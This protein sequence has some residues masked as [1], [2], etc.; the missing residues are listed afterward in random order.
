MES[1]HKPLLILTGPTGAGKT[2][3]SLALAESAAIQIINIDRGQWYTPLT[4]GTAKPAWRESSVKQWLFD[5]CDTPELL[6][7]VS[8]RKRVIE[9]IEKIEN[10]GALPVLVG[11]SLF[12]IESLLYPP[13]E[14]PALPKKIYE[15]S[16]EDLALIDPK[17][18]QALHPNDTYR[19]KRALSIWHGSGILPSTLEPSFSPFRKTVIAYLSPE[20]PQLYERI[21]K[22]VHIMIEQG[23]LEETY[24]LLDTPW[25]DFVRKNSIIGYP[26]LIEYI[27]KGYQQNEKDGMIDQISAQT[28]YYAKKQECFFKRLERKIKQENSAFATSV[29]L[30]PGNDNAKTLLSL[31]SL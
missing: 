15:G 8:Y 13:K 29:R 21:N 7:V 12:Y 30:A 22:R 6:S 19:I 25:E 26:E 1:L 31:C 4:I 17:R 24:A 28:R 23:W 27:R 3:L 14:V 2:D 9:T 18:A 16:W 20:R 10:E 11:G 5:I